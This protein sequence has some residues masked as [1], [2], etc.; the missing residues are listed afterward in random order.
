MLAVAAVLTALLTGCADSPQLRFDFD[1]PAGIERLELAIHQG[2][3]PV[4]SSAGAMQAGWG[5]DVIVEDGKT[6]YRADP[7]SGA[8]LKPGRYAVQVWG[9]D[10]DCA[11]SHYDCVEF[12]SPPGDGA[13]PVVL[14]SEAAVECKLDR[15]VNDVCTCPAGQAEGPTGCVDRDDCMAM[16]GQCAPDEECRNNAGSFEC[17]CAMGFDD[18]GDGCEPVLT[19]LSVS[20]GQLVPSFDPAV[21]QYEVRVGLTRDALG[22]TA[23]WE[24]GHQV[25]ITDERVTSGLEVTRPVQFGESV[26]Q[27]R[28]AAGDKSREYALTVKRG[29]AAY[30]KASNPRSLASFGDA[31][32]VS[33]D[34]NTLA[35]GAPGDLSCSSG[36]NGDQ[37][38]AGCDFAGAAYVFVRVDGAWL[39]QAY[40]K[41]SNAPS[42]QLFGSALAIGA[43][44][45]KLFVGAPGEKSC[46][47]DQDDD[48]C[49]SAGAV[50][51][52]ERDPSGQWRQFAYLK[53]TN[54]ARASRFG[55]ALAV[56]DDASTIAV[57]APQADSCPPGDDCP[58][59]GAVHVF[60]LNGD[61]FS[62]TRLTPAHPGS[63]DLFGSAL[64]LNG[65]G[66]TLVVGA[67]GNN[68]CEEL[69]V[70]GAEQ[71]C[72]ASGAVH[73]FDRVEGS[74]SQSKFLRADPVVGHANFGASVAVSGNNDVVAVGAPCPEADIPFRECD[75]GGAV[76][77]F[78]RPLGFWIESPTLRAST[79]E[80]KA[81]G[82]SVQVNHDGSL[83][84]VAAPKEEGCSTFPETDATVLGCE[85]AG[86]VYLLATEQQAWSRFMYL[87]ATNTEAKDGF[88]SALALARDGA[89]V[90]VGAPREDSSEAGPGADPQNNG[91]SGSG[92]AFVFE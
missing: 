52:F 2:G 62:Q 36:I 33:E 54:P 20:Q 27:V 74:W 19:S 43:E 88:G 24:G 71:S 65:S 14:T 81:V 3:C 38:D 64:A 77:V 50:Y 70:A 79:T 91:S 73:V 48:D 60:Q 39:Q 9:R 6:Q 5:Y 35:V 1:H 61:T 76:H 80:L 63:L 17:A 4:E 78:R 29:A 55:S 7:G 42:A 44:G 18:F 82:S 30:L 51:A 13:L 49:S 23:S 34:G 75:D 90:V 67:P 40:V 15:C 10:A 37:T 86:G 53:A 56:S 87:K 47:L 92:A 46:S 25:S 69:D 57:G 68:S 59:S 89:M 12:N 28:V 31:V 72:V 8:D 32:A 66:S 26:L 16:P 83:I 22:V 41:A 21:T 45:N 11:W 85:D 84:A 58:G